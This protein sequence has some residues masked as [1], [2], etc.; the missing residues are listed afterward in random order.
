LPPIEAAKP[1][2][3]RGVSQNID[4]IDCEG[5]DAGPRWYLMITERSRKRC[6]THSLCKRCE[7]HLE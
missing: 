1:A 6:Q 4:A 5:R 7:A 3:R 2:S